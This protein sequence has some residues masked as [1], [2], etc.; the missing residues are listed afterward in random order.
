MK[1]VQRKEVQ[2]RL[3]RMHELL[4]PERYGLNDENWS[5][6]ELLETLGEDVEWLME[7]VIKDL[8]ETGTLL[9]RIKRTLEL[10]IEGN[11][12]DRLVLIGDMIEEIEQYMDTKV[13]K[14]V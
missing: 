5:N 8:E 10:M 6:T 12:T 9:E 7:V 3:S 11:E 1:E 4:F 2:E 13:N 14:D